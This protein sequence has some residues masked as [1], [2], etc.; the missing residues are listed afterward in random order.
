MDYGGE[1]TASLWYLLSPPTGQSLS[2]SVPN[3]GTAPTTV[4]ISSYKAQAKHTTAFDATNQASH[5][6]SANPTVSVAS[7][8]NGDVYVDSL[9][10]GNTAVPTANNRVLL[11]SNDTGVESNA[12]QYYLQATSANDAMSYT[13][14]SDDWFIVA[15]CFKEVQIFPEAVHR[16]IE[17]PFFPK[18]SYA[19]QQKPLFE[20][21]DPPGVFEWVHRNIEQPYFAK[22]LISASGQKN[23]SI[24]PGVDLPGYNRTITLDQ[25]ASDLT[26]FPVLI[27]GTY[28]YLKTVA[29][30][31]KVENA[32]G[33]DITFYSDSGLTTLLKFER[34]IWVA[35]TGVVEFWVKIPTLTSAVP[36]IIY[37]S[38]GNTAITTDQQD[39]VNVWDADYK[40]VWHLPDGT[41]LT[42]NDSTG[43]NND[44]TLT[45]TPT[46]TSGKIDGAANFASAS[47]Q[48][49]TM[50]DVIEAGTNAITLEAWAN[51][52]DVNQVATIIGKRS[53]TAPFFIQY[54]MLVGYVASG[55][56][57]TASKQISFFITSDGI[58]NAISKRTT[59][60]VADGSFHH[61]VVTYSG[62]TVLIYID[63]SSVAL[64]TDITGTPGNVDNDGAFRIAHDGTNFLNC[65]VDEARVSIGIA[66][67]ATWIATEYSNQNDPAN[68]YTIGPEV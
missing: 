26:N 9:F 41:T 32:N 55:G 56:I 11:F 45:N 7:S 23:I 49:I 43:N 46:A 59:A 57:F 1:G 54:E 3:S 67:S 24:L 27:S 47:S 68:F 53:T 38:Y 18:K 50:G 15:A 58:A 64:T 12:A 44:G 14:T 34:V 10:S 35:T 33:Y 4:I 63:G 60:N 2:V 22:T 62:T 36:T 21:P 66:R 61:V 37:L 30:G 31:G 65:A 29:N 51:P 5:T 28:T 42:A 48:Y 25:P 13:A 52:A 17:Q 19:K 16:N 40:G 39:A 20:T 6:G 8:V